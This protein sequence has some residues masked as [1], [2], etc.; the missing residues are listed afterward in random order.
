MK[1][2]FDKLAKK[3]LDDSIE[4]YEIEIK[5]LGIRFREEIKRSLRIIKKMP[6]I[7]SPESENVRRYILHKF[8]CKI[9][10]SNEKDH[11]YIVA[12]AHMHREPKY[13]TNR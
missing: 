12:I 13:W 6:K 11:I 3:E 1:V 5:G 4:Y 9:L 7:G 2:I 10:Y 8:P